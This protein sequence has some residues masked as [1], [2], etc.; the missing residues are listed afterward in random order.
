MG[1]KLGRDAK[2]RDEDV[3]KVR[4][5]NSKPAP[6]FSLSGYGNGGPISS[7]D[8]KGRVFLLNFWFP[9]CGPCHGEFPYVQHA[10]DKYKDQGFAIVAVNVQQAQDDLV[11]PLLKGLKL[12]FLPVKTDDKI[13]VAYGV[14]GAPTSFLIGPDGRIWFK[15]GP[16]FDAAKQ[17]TLELQIEALL[18]MTNGAQ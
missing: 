2:L 11:L 8:F 7:A 10:L 13:E 18:Q 12:G 9:E 16:V 4:E 3:L 6:A 5:A 14:H 15:T 1:Q 17:R